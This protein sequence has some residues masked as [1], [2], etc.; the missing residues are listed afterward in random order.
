ME[1]N[2]EVKL[3]FIEKKKTVLPHSSNLQA[4]SQSMDHAEFYSKRT[5]LDPHFLHNHDRIAALSQY[6]LNLKSK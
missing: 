1:T 5:A 3:E 2:D 6:Q 4:S